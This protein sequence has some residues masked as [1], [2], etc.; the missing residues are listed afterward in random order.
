MYGCSWDIY[1]SLLIGFGSDLKKKVGALFE[2]EV[3]GP[4][5]TQNNPKKSMNSTQAFKKISTS[6]KNHQI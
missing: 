3:W 5:C 4:E 1:L 2:L 6:L